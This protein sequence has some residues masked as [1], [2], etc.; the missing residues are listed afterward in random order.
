MPRYVKGDVVWVPFPFSATGDYKSRPALILASW[1][2][3]KST[4]YHLCMISTQVDTDPYLTELTNADMVDGSM[5]RTCYI[6]PTYNFSADENFIE[7][8]VGKL[9]PEK[10]KAVLFTLFKVLT[11]D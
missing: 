4:D 3:K 11:Q 10:V 1:P 9:C 5:S 7:Y 2:Y 6:R 8:R